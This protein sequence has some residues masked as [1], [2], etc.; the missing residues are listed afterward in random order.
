MI[1]RYILD[2]FQISTNLFFFS[3]LREIRDC[4]IVN[5]QILY[6]Y[7]MY[8]KFFIYTIFNFDSF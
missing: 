2:F 6:N 1:K 8:S 5:S 7:F 4:V 3:Y